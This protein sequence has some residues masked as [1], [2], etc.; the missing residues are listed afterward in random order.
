MPGESLKH[1]SASNA[2]AG[3]GGSLSTPHSLETGAFRGGHS[4]KPQRV[5]L[6][7]L[8]TSEVRPRGIHQFSCL[9]GGGVGWGC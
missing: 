7:I 1:V 4:G 9:T 8:L 6:A 2:G 5:K 3:V